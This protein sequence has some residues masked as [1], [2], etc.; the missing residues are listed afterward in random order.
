MSSGTHMPARRCGQ[1]RLRR[2]K[3][4]Q[5]QDSIPPL[6]VTSD[7]VT[8][9]HPIGPHTADNASSP[10]ERS[11]SHAADFEESGGGGIVTEIYELAFR[12][13]PGPVTWAAFPEFELRREKGLTVFRGEFVDQAG[14]HGVIERVNSLGLELVDVRLVADDNP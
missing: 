12:G 6:Q 3:E 2:G 7:W 10:G 13:E 4:S 11:P 8:D 9:D 5:R 14:L 1:R